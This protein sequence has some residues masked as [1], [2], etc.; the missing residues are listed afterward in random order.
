MPDEAKAQPP[1]PLLPSPD[2]ILRSQ[3]VAGLGSQ[4]PTR[5]KRVFLFF[6]SDASR[7]G[8]ISAVSPS[9]STHRALPAQLVQGRLQMPSNVSRQSRNDRFAPRGVGRG[10]RS[11][12]DG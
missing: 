10:P 11:S 3:V 5:A 12:D 9:E 8:L 6:L 4:L 1:D 2:E 7:K